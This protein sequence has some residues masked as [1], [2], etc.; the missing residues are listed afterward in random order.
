MRE[1]FFIHHINHACV[2]VITPYSSIIT[3]PWISGYCFADKLRLE[4][5]SSKP[6]LDK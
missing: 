3:D 6:K 5:Q 1:N 4:S 2:E